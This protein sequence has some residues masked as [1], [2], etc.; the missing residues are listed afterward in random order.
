MYFQAKTMSAIQPDSFNQ[1]VYTYSDSIDSKSEWILK[2]EIK[3]GFWS[4]SEKS[5]LRGSSQDKGQSRILRP[6]EKWPESHL[7][8]KFCRFIRQFRLMYFTQYYMR[9]FLQLIDIIIRVN[10]DDRADASSSLTDDRALS[11]VDTV[12]ISTG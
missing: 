7:R 11:I 12:P 3:L 10:N 5:E 2:R 8:V 4:T 1:S 6:D 9:K